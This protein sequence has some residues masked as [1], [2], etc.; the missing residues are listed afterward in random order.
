VKYTLA[1]LHAA[2]DDPPFGSLYLNA[3]A[4]L[5]TWWNA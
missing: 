1:C 3:A 2:A 4:H 5:V